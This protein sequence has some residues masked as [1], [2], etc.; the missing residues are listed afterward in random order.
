MPTASFH[1][2]DQDGDVDLVLPHPKEVV[3]YL[4]GVLECL[5]TPPRLNFRRSNTQEPCSTKSSKKGRKG[6]KGAPELEPRVFDESPA[7]P[8]PE[9][10]A[11]APES[12]E[13]PETPTTPEA[14][15]LAIPEEPSDADPTGSVL[16]KEDATSTP[17][18]NCI[19]IRASSKHLTLASSY[20]KRNLGSGMLE[21]HTLSSQGHVEFPFSQH[22]LGPRQPECLLVRKVIPAT[23]LGQYF[24]RL[25]NFCR[26]FIFPPSTQQ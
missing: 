8:E 11:E 21:S 17:D 23:S 7:E 18:E 2:I 1:Q 4:D 12:D 13:Y 26:Y 3:S 5:P 22:I 6:K 16:A 20:F 24:L 15:A 19:R 14:E 25:L 9:S 10:V